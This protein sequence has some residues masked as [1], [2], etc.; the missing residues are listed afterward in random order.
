MSTRYCKVCWKRCKS[1][2]WTTAIYKGKRVEVCHDCKRAI[3]LKE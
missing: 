1:R 3:E 2:E